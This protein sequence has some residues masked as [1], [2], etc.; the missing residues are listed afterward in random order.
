MSYGA[1]PPDEI[2][3]VYRPVGLSHVFTA[4]GPEM[5]G[6]HISH[7]SLQVAFGLAALGL[8]RHVTSLYGIEANYEIQCS[9]DDF[10]SHL[11]G[12]GQQG[13]F[14]IARITH[15]AAGAYVAH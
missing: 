10:L 7:P 12:E 9:Y 6:F 11:K 15:E 2:T 13:N 8:G 1:S 5:S 14:V 4:T 3:L